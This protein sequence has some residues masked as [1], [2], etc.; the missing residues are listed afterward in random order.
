[1]KQVKIEVKN[2][3][4]CVFVEVEKLQ[5]LDKCSYFCLAPGQVHSGIYD[6]EYYFNNYKSPNWCP[7]KKQSLKIEFKK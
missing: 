5:E 7:L 2:C 3:K 4:N 6:I 1:M